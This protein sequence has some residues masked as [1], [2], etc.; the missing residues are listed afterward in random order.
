MEHV[1]Y[2][3]KTKSVSIPLNVVQIGVW[4]ILLFL[5]NIVNMM[6][7]NILGCVHT[8]VLIRI[9]A[10]DSFILSSLNAACLPKI[11]IS[12]SFWRVGFTNSNQQLSELRP[13]LNTSGLAQQE[14]RGEGTT[15]RIYFHHRC[16]RIPGQVY[17][18]QICTPANFCGST[19]NSSIKVNRYK[20]H[21]ILWG[22][23]QFSWIS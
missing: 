6:D 20:I 10:E 3:L 12:K 11:R 23:P 15:V 22:T 2:K 21:N 17:N 8:R 13:G 4:E 19:V 14:Q 7:L 16:M 9:S 1:K 18:T 5:Y